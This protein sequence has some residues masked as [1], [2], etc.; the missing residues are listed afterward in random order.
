MGDVAIAD[1]PASIVSKAAL[2]QWKIP[3]E[4]IQDV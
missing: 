3:W 1:A 2:S 4:N